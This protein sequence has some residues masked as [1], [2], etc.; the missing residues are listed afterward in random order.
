MKPIPG[1]PGYH[2]SE[3]GKITNP[4]GKLLTRKDAWEGYPRARLKNEEGKFVNR[5]IHRL[6][7]LAHLGVNDGEI[8]HKDNNRANVAV[9]N[10]EWGDRFSNAQDRLARGSYHLKTKLVGG[11][12]L[13]VLGDDKYLDP[14]AKKVYKVT[15]HPI[16]EE[17][18]IPVTSLEKVAYYRKYALIDLDTGKIQ[19]G[20]NTYVNSEEFR[21]RHIEKKA[22]L[23]RFLKPNVAEHAFDAVSSVQLPGGMI[24]N[25]VTSAKH[26]YQ[27]I[28][29]HLGGPETLL[30]KKK[31][32]KPSPVFKG[33]NI[34]SV[35]HGVYTKRGLKEVTASKLYPEAHE[36]LFNRFTPIELL[37]GIKNN[38][39]F[40]GNSIDYIKA[41]F[42]PRKLVDKANAGHEEARKLVKEFDYARSGFVKKAEWTSKKNADSHALKH[43]DEM[44]LT[45]EQYI[46]LAKSALNDK[47]SLISIRGD[48]HKSRHGKNILVHKDGKV[49]TYY[50]KVAYIRKI[51]KG[52]E[53]GIDNFQDWGYH[54]DVIQT[55]QDIKEK[56]K[57]K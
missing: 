5:K 37:K 51:K 54:Q 29:P 57:K 2:I 27:G 25:A 22:F 53:R 6:V 38:R 28:K 47:K 30:T 56:R 19:S 11:K 35:Q 20:L 10:L 21:K 9:H 33:L 43:A 48:I 46:A 3:D 41:N 34:P 8:R 16:G 14:E 40:D 52:L 26:A 12:S 23:R 55:H 4:K 1:F 7:A 44:G 50:S 13:L 45:K 36:L 42:H 15:D 18:V 49:I 32:L 39:K 31:I 17:G 24:G